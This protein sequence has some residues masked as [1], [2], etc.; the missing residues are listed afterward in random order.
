[1]K[2]LK[3]TFAVALIATSALVATNAAETLLS[4]RAAA[5]APREAVAPSAGSPKTMGCMSGTHAPAGSTGGSGHC[6]APKDGRAVMSCC[7]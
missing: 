4:P 6:K 3:L 5:N 7:K 1:M 2:T